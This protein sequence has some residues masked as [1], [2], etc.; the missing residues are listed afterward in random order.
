MGRMSKYLSDDPAAHEQRQ[1][2]VQHQ[3]GIYFHSL[4]KTYS[5][6]ALIPSDKTV[7]PSF[8]T[9]MGGSVVL[10]GVVFDGVTRS[11]AA[12]L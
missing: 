9:S 7:K 1:C 10:L 5:A 4:V 12:I 3:Y 8:R 2:L 11:S 6:I